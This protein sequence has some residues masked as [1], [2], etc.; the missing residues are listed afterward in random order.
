M[1]K[2]ML[3]VVIRFVF[4]EGFISVLYKIVAFFVLSYGRRSAIRVGL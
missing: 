3:W 2:A 4:V 1:G